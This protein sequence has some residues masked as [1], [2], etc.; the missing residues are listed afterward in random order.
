MSLTG[1]MTTSSVQST[2]FLLF[3]GHTGRAHIEIQGTRDASSCQAT[4]VGESTP[5]RAPV[6]ASSIAFMALSSARPSAAAVLGCAGLVLVGW[7][8]QLVPSLIRSIEPAFAQ[9]DA[10]IG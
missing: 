3:A 8:G 1:R 2:R 4:P 10:G 6:S 9:T 5:S 7:A